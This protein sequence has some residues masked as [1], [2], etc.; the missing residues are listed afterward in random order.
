[1]AIPTFNE[2]LASTKALRSGH[3]AQSMVSH[4]DRCLQ[5]YWLSLNRGLISRETAEHHKQEVIVSLMRLLTAAETL[6]DGLAQDAPSGRPLRD[7]MGAMTGG[8]VNLIARMHSD[9]SSVGGGDGAAQ[10]ALVQLRLDALE[11]FTA[12][13]QGMQ[14]PALVARERQVKL[15]AHG[16][17]TDTTYPDFPPKY[18]NEREREQY[19]VVFK[20]G[21]AKMHPPLDP[22]RW[23]DADTSGWTDQQHRVLKHFK[24][25]GGKQGPNVKLGV[26]GFAVSIEKKMYM[27]HEHRGGGSLTHQRR[28]RLADDNDQVFYH[29][30][31]MAG[32]PVVCAGSIAF[33]NGLPQWLTNLSGHYAP[34]PSQLKWVID[35]FDMFGVPTKELH[36][37]FME[38]D[39]TVWYCT[40]AEFRR[41]E[42]S[43][44]LW[45]EGEMPEAG[46]FLWAKHGVWP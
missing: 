1:M 6:S 11:S 43:H 40:A 44:P 7:R 21:K 4:I 35:L 8:G 41:D 45:R 10:R 3:R 37:V 38:A 14:T 42:H 23:I 46:G 36:V 30:S 39:Q 20:D 29:S 19:R 25:R 32:S 22:V 34:P 27:S 5:A 9:R 12:L 28:R 13:S 2:W 15:N 17:K 33:K 24:D 16:I 18:L 26:G 31:Y